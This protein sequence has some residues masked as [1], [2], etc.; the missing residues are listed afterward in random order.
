MRTVALLAAAL[1]AG[2]AAG[3]AKGP[4]K[5]LSRTAPDM[6]PVVQPREGK[7]ETI[8]LF[9]GKTLN[10]WEG[11]SDLW[12]VKDGVI[13]G[14]NKEPLKYSTYLWTK[15]KYSDFRIIFGFRLGEEEEMHS[16]LAFWG[17]IDPKPDSK[18]KDEKTDRTQ[19]TYKG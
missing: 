11:Y 19:H 9:D 15:D 7:S 2:L 17:S 5:S 8:H 4:P 16:G 14:K 1:T 10:G 12:S 13:T 6:A 18:V 3:Q